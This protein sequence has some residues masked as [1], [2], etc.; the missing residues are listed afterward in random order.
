MNSDELKKYL[1]FGLGIPLILWGGLNTLVG[2]LY[3]IVSSEIFK[4]II[5]QAFFWGFIDLILGLFVFFSKK[6]RDRSKIR[7]ILL[8][9]IFLDIGYIVGGII[10]V[11]LSA[12]Q[13]YVGSGYG[14]IIQG[15]FL[16]CADL[17]HYM[18]LRE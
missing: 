6:A 5:I 10:L 4:G 18:K 16:F 17:I 7:K 3:F 8:V 13:I 1:K 14:V 2:A 11:V 9:N 12:R 15:T